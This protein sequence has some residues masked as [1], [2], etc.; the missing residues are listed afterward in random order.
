[1]IRIGY[2][3]HK[4][5]QRCILIQIFSKNGRKYHTG[6]PQNKTHIAFFQNSV[7]DGRCGLIAGTADDKT[8]VGYLYYNLIPFTIVATKADKLSR[9]QTDKSLASIAA[10]YKCGKGDIIASSSVTRK[11]LD[12]V[13]SV[14]E[15]VINPPLI[16]EE[17][18][19]EPV[20]EGEN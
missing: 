9:A 8:M 20:D 11:G 18:E 17:G 1:M 3:M 12:E 6:R 16:E 13:L 4:D 19:E 7:S 14:I 5:L 10:A 15:R 2:G